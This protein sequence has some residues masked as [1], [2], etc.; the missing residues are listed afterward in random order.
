MAGTYGPACAADGAGS[1]L[2]DGSIYKAAR[3]SNFSDANI[4]S[5]ITIAGVAGSATLENHVNCSTDGATGCIATASY[6]SADASV[7][8]NIKNGV[9]LAGVTGGYPSGL[10]PLT[11]ASAGVTDLPAFSATTGGASYEWFASDGTHLTGSIEGDESVVPGT[12]TQTLNVGLYRSVAVSGDADLVASNIK[13]GINIFGVAGSVI[14]SAGDCSA[15]GEVGC[16]TTAAFKAADLSNLVSGN[17]KNGVTIAG[18]AGTYPSLASPLAGADGG[19]TDLIS[20]AATTAAGAYEFF[21]STGARYTGSIADAG[22][23]APSASNQNFNTALYRQFTVS[24]D[25]D[26]SAIN[27]KS[28]VNIFGVA[29]SL[30]PAPANCSANAEEGCV[31]TATFKAADLSNLSAGNIKNGVVLAGVT[32]DYPSATNPLTGAMGGVADLPAFASTTGGTTYEWFSSDGTRLSDAVEANESVTPGTT[33]QTLNAGLYRSVSVDGDA[34]LVATNIKTGISVFGVTGNV[35]PSAANCSSDGEVGCVTTASFKAAD[36]LQ[37]IPG[38]IKIGEV[39]AG[40]TGALSGAPA[41]CSVNGEQ[42]CVTTATFKAADLSNLLSAN[43]KNGVT[44]AGTAGTYPSLATP[45]SG[46]T[47]TADLTSLAGNAPAGSY[48]FFDSVGTRYSG[49]ISDA[50]TITPGTSNQNFTASVYRQFTVTGDTD[51]IAGN[52]RSGISIFGVTGTVTASPAN[53]SANAEIGCVT[54]VTFK[55]ADLSNLS[56]A[57][58]KSGIVLAG[59]TGD[60]PSATNLLAG[61]TGTADLPAFA[62]TT[63]GTAYEWFNADGSR[64]TGSIETNPTVTPSASAQTLNAGLYRSVTVNGDADLVAGNINSGVNIFGVTGTLTPSPAACSANDVVGCVTTATY[65]SADLTN[66]LAGNIKNGVT[67]AGTAGTYPSLTTPL[68]GASGTSDLTSMAANTPAGSYEFFDSTGTRYVGSITDASTI[69]ASVTAQNFNAS[70]YRQFTVAGD[71]DLVAA[72]I[73]TGINIF[74]VAGTMIPSPANCSAD[75]QTGCVTTPTYK[76]ADTGAFV[77][78]DIKS[79][80]TIAGVAGALVNCTTDGGTGCVTTATYKAANMTNVTAANIRSGVTIAGQA[81]DYPS[82]TN[83]LAGNTVATDL[84]SLGA[85]VAAGSYEWFKSDG[86]LVSGSIADAGTIT[87]NAS[88]QNFTASVYRQFTVNGDADLVA[89]NIKNAIS[90]FGVTGNVVAETHTDCSGNA[91]TGCVTTGTY[92]SADLTNLT[93]G[94]VKNGV[95]IAGVAGGYPSATYLLSGQDGTTDLPVFAS[96]TGGTSYE[97]FQADGTR[98]T[99]AVQANQ[100]VTPSAGGTTLNSGLYRSVTVNG[101]ADLVAGKIKSG[102]DIFGVVGGYPS[103]TYPLTGADATAD[104]DA[105]TFDAKMKSATCS[106]GLSR[107]A[108]VIQTQV[109]PISLLRILSQEFPFSLRLVRLSQEARVS[110]MERWAA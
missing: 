26:L 47:G 13:T 55:A 22:T 48:E 10:Y 83:P 27:I 78:S 104:L 110:A 82:A 60:Y 14:P 15:N 49:N 71:A 16:V 66:L 18:T 2:V 35:V 102:V 38:N 33:T 68:V 28:G 107:T 75:N 64:L 73:G 12:S 88:N 96:T 41:N 76:S 92:Q 9:V 94:N 85:S 58:V 56:A 29:G 43:I 90:I 97:W 45:L 100:T 11:G 81:G 37:A 1:C 61:N 65:K 84:P 98:L 99:S 53:C 40:V 3:L 63:G 77:A 21:D 8:G 25:S 51:L 5:G 101:D 7:A 80:K 72:N 105:A 89:G 106:N 59:V 103:V 30:T 19:V 108:H 44:V 36:M 24:G 54:T 62:S 52:I 17:I 20:L 70:L 42:G 86:T 67:I 46:A 6:P 93:A 91:Q 95:T 79:G 109:T 57:N 87:P 50:A 23:I 39:V 31:T 69:T 34:D 32:G 4:E 74:G